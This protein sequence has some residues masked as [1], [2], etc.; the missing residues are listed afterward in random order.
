MNIKANIYISLKSNVS[1]PQGIT[2]AQGLEQLGFQ[3]IGSVRAGK[4][5]EVTIT[6]PS[7]KQAENIIKK[8]CDELL[9]NPIIEDYKFDLNIIN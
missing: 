5:I 1:D 9:Y 4:Y 6:A 3:G 8:M 2:I 7:V